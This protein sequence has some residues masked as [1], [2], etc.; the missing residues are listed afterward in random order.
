M[1]PL[2]SF[3]D[4]INLLAH[5]LQFVLALN[6]LQPETL[7]ACCPRAL[8]PQLW[9]EIHIDC[10]PGYYKIV[11]S[12]TELFVWP[13]CSARNRLPVWTCADAVVEMNQRRACAD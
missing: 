3:D 5:V 13:G 7:T 10:A 1:L 11:N 6:H 8:L 2:P 9:I 12:L 4:A